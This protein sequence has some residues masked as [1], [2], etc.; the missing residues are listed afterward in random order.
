[1]EKP[2]RKWCP[3]ELAGRRCG[4]AYLS[5]LL[6]PS[7]FEMCGFAPQHFPNRIFHLDTGLKAVDSTSYRLS[8]LRSQ[9]RSNIS[10]LSVDFLGRFVAAAESWLTQVTI[11][12]KDPSS[13]HVKVLPTSV[14]QL[15]LRHQKNDGHVWHH[16]GDNGLSWYLLVKYNHHHFIRTLRRR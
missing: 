3:L 4:S 14:C 12:L 11:S 7:F 9:A 16:P 6:L 8:L 5:L 2:E 10:S 1:M 13:F 15:D